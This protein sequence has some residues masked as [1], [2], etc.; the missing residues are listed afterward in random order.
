[1]NHERIEKLRAILPPDEQDEL[2]VLHNAYVKTLKAYQ[3]DEQKSADKLKANRAAKTALVELVE[4]L[5]NR[6]LSGARQ[7]RSG[8]DALRYLQKNGWKIEKSKL[9]EDRN[10]GLITF[11]TDKSVDEA[12]L[13]AYAAKFLDKVKSTGAGDQAGALAEQKLSEDIEHRRLQKE[14]LRFEIA[15][16]KG[17][18]IHRSKWLTELVL[19]LSAS[20][21]IVLQVAR[22]RAPDLIAASGGDLKKQALFVELFSDYIENAFNELVMVPELQFMVHTDGRNQNG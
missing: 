11:N 4:S 14:K 22:D 6:Y 21:F 17:Q 8:M 18:Y 16:E 5:E 15:R 10:R 20:K 7:L 9:Y 2:A 12:E 13:L 1:M 19:K 3:A